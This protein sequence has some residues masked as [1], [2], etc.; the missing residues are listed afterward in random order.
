MKNILLVDDQEENLYILDEMLVPLGYKIFKSENGEEA[1]KIL[2][3]EKIDLVL[4]DVHMPVMDG[5]ELCKKIKKHEETRYIPVVL[6]SAVKKELDDIVSGID[7]GADD[8]MA[9]PIERSLLIA[10]VRAMLRLKELNEK[11]VEAEILKTF[12]AL[13][14]TAN[15]EINNPLNGIVGNIELLQTEDLSEEDKKEM[16]DAIHEQAMKVS[17]IVKRFSTITEPVRKKY[18]GGIEM[19]DLDKSK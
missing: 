2:N 3:K 5:V 7:E 6:L 13:A 18:A 4:S 15:H 10:K 9:K 14:I 19:I 16:Y 17:E 11:L 1:L 8:Y 12:T